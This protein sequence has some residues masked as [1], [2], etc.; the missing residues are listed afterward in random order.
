M[1]KKIE[2]AYGP[3][4]T[5]DEYQDIAMDLALNSAMKSFRN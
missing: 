3:G 4:L 2:S 1:I 5:E